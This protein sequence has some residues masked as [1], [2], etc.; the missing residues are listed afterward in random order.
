[1]AKKASKKDEETLVSCMDC[2]Q[3]T[4]MQWGNDP[5]IAEC[6]ARKDREVARFKRFCQQHELEKRL[7]KPIRHLPKH[8]GQ[9]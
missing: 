9:Q 3:A 4:L 1:M 2:T 7:P 6:K 5:I 8:I